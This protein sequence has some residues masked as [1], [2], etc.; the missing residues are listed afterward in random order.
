MLLCEDVVAS[1][2]DN[3][4][5]VV[6]VKYYSKGVSKYPNNTR[7]HYVLLGLLRT[8]ILRRIFNFNCVRYQEFTCFSTIKVWVKVLFRFRFSIDYFYKPIQILICII[9]I[10]TDAIHINQFNKS[11]LSIHRGFLTIII[12]HIL[13]FNRA[14]NRYEPIQNFCVQS[15]I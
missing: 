5:S 12:R 8:T 3:N 13:H 15:T 14:I 11:F 2:F 1:N 7:Q 9:D 10:I 4:T 6:H